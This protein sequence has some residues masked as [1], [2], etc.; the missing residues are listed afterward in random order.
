MFAVVKFIASNS[1]AV[2]PTNWLL[3][4][5]SS[6]QWPSATTANIVKLVKNRSH[7]DPASCRTYKVDVIAVTETYDKA[8]QK[9]RRAEETDDVQT[10]T[11][12]GDRPLSSSASQLRC[13]DS[14]LACAS[15]SQRSSPLSTPASDSQHS[16]GHRLSNPTY[17]SCSS[18][19]PS[20][21]ELRSQGER[22]LCIPGIHS[23]G[24][25]SRPTTQPSSHELPGSFY[26]SPHDQEPLMV[27]TM[28]YQHHRGRSGS[29]VALIKKEISSSTRAVLREIE[30]VKC[31]N[32][33]ILTC[34]NSNKLRLKSTVMNPLCRF[35]RWLK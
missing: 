4:D 3:E 31:Q 28:S 15:S 10:S 27:D 9:L 35:F 25:D 33:L 23:R 7:L 32:D 12:Q 1:V 24:L 2:V 34:S 26:S 20:T 30:F 5:T 14:P 21:G 13:S 22:Q 17:L 19:T 8:H 16:G 6:C 18:D 29:L 11:D